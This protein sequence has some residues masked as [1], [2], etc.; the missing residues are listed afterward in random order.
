MEKGKSLTAEQIQEES[1]RWDALRQEVGKTVVGYKK[2]IDRIIIGLLCNGH[3][4]LEGA[5]GLAKTTLVRSIAKGTGLTFSRIQFTPDLLPS[6]IIGTLIYNPKTQEFITKKG[7]IFAGVVLADEINRAP[8]KVQSSLLEAMQEHQVTIGDQ[9]YP[10]ETPFIVLATQNPVDQEGTYSLPE[11][12]VDRFMLKLNLEY[13]SREDELEII[14]TVNHAKTIQQVLNKD[15]I[16]RSQ[17]YTEAVFVDPKINEYITDIV[18]MTRPCDGSP[19]FIKN[20]VRFGAS[21]RAVIA[22]HKASKAHALIKKRHFVIPDDVKAV[23]FDALRHRIIL[24]YEAEID[25]LQ[26]DD[27][28]KEILNTISTP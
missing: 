25:N 8:A 20:A 4:L 11:A 24:T 23:V 7:P 14:N 10:I 28:I 26:A 19:S 9:S 13:P 1:M 18:R 12:Q 21:P 22:I 27:V 6:D 17:K 15:D 2:I 5:P 16:I 3:I